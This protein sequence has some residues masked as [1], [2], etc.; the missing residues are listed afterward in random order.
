[1]IC[2]DAEIRSKIFKK[3]RH[4]SEVDELKE[5]SEASTSRSAK[6][7]PLDYPS[8]ILG[9]PIVRVRDLAQSYDSYKPPDY[10]PALPHHGGEMIT[11]RAGGGDTESLNLSATLTIRTSGT[12]PKIKYYLE[13]SGE[14]RHLVSQFISAAV[15]EVV[16]E[17]LLAKACDLRSSLNVMELP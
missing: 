12:E 3:L 2:H 1:V 14:D 5:S 15:N 17:W 8:S 16:E 13:G 4:W 10:K 11:F 7:E 6:V 9:L